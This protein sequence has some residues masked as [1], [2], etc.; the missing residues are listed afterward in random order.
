MYKCNASMFHIKIQCQHFVWWLGCDLLII[1]SV[2]I[3]VAYKISE[4][5]HECQS[6][7]SKAQY[8]VLKYL[9][10]STAHKDINCHRGIKK[11]K[12]ENIHI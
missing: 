3:L 10:L 4:N 8:E 12:N 6:V 7:F 9:A 1:L 2:N 5:R 11:E